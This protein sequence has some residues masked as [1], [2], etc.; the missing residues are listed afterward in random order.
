MRFCFKKKKP[1][2]ATAA[3]CSPVRP[4]GGP[5]VCQTD[6]IDDQADVSLMR[7]CQKTA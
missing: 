4:F 3:S 1:C 6:D 2:S 5:A 7:S